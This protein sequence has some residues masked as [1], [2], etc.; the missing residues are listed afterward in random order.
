[1]C[2]TRSVYPWD[3]V[4]DVSEDIFSMIRRQN[5]DIELLEIGNAIVF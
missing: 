4:V 3:I 2:C 1:M 5:N